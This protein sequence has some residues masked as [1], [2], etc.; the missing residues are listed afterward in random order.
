MITEETFA[1]EEKR[2]GKEVH[3]HDGVWWISSA[4]FYFKPV[5]EYRPFA[6][7]SARPH[8]LKALLGYSHQVFDPAQATRYKRMNILAGDDLRSFS[9]ERLENKRK[10]RRGIK[11]C[12]VEILTPSEVILEQMR[13][14]NIS[15]AKKHESRGRPRGTF[16][17]HDYYERNAVQWKEN[18]RKF[19]D[20]QG[21]QFIGA[22]VGETLV[23]YINLIQIEDTWVFGAV[24]SCHEYLGHR[25]VD[26]LYF[27]ILSMASQSRE[28]KRVVNGGGDYEPESLTHFKRQYLFKLV[29]LP[30]YSW[31]LLPMDWLRA[32]KNRTMGQRSGPI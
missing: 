9:L 16:L 28:C 18:T 20:H 8:T 24:K 32:F 26:V 30:Y 25:P 15:A 4:P 21:H 23:A 13:R 14:I 29:P 10:V 5:H 1:K 6:R 7:K 27:T 22:F 31:T 2:L 19:F 3:F 11:D 17:L 12:R